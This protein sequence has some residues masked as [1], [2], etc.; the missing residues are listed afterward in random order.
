MRNEED[1]YEEEVEYVPERDY[2]KRTHPV[3]MIP[4]DIKREFHSVRRKFGMDIANIVLFAYREW[5]VDVARSLAKKILSFDSHDE[6]YRFLS[7]KI[8][9]FDERSRKILSY[10]MQVYKYTHYVDELNQIISELESKCPGVRDKAFSLYHALALNGYYYTPDCIVLYVLQ[11]LNCR[12]TYVVN[13]RCKNVFDNI[14]K[15]GE[16]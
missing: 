3:D 11:V 6:L 5:G 16:K 10:L 8:D 12:E 9:L 13:Q 1:L 7:S 14:R 15:L 4:S 2:W